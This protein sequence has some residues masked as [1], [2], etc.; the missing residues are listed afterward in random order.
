MQESQVKRAL[1][2]DKKRTSRQIKLV[3]LKDF[4]KPI[5]HEVTLS[6][7]LKELKRQGWLVQ[8]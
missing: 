1:L 3:L 7:F 4:A 2:Q 5:L 8:K 6:D